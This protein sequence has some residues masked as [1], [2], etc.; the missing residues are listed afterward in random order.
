MVDWGPQGVET[1]KQLST[2]A[3]IVLGPNASQST[4]VFD[5][6][7]HA[8]YYL[9]FDSTLV[10]LP[11]QYDVTRVLLE[12]FADKAAAVP[13][14]ADVYGILAFSGAA[15]PFATVGGRLLAQDMMHGPFMRMTFR[16]LQATDTVSNAYTLLGTSRIIPGPY[17]REVAQADGAIGPV[18]EESPDNWMLP[19]L[20]SSI[21]GLGVGATVNFPGYLRYGTCR[22][23]TMLTA[24][25][26][27]INV[28]YGTRLIATTDEQFAVAPPSVE[29]NM[30]APKGTPLVQVVNTGGVVTT[31]TFK[32]VSQN[33]K[34]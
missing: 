30:I 6:R 23:L 25:A 2:G 33:V 32:F 28:F 14:Y 9:R 20:Q 34:F 10:G 7:Q 31:V 3:G 15:A 8:S 16:N 13:V 22:L 1:V 4:E 27:T 5:V 26:V 29:R 21:A 11:T 12:W 24:G 18:R 19:P 17:V